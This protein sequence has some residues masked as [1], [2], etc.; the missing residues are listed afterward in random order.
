[1]K[2]IHAHTADETGDVRKLYEEAFPPE[3]KKPFSLILK[4]SDEGQMEIL[5]LVD[6]RGTFIG[7]AISI[8]YQDLALLDYLAIA[9]HRRGC[10]HG[11][12][13][14]ALLRERYAGK[15]FLLEIE[16]TDERDAANIADRIRRKRFYL[17]NGM[18]EMPYR[19]WLFGVRMQ[20]LTDGSNVSFP[21][22]HAI[23]PAVFSRRAGENVRLY[24]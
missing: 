20:I 19:V 23:F 22:Y 13:A 10:G 11:S 5:R 15:R 2:L 8:L 1:M 16:D 17:R 6:D 21:E 14:L 24:P 4:K 9:P 18:Q 7:L 12:Q 3:E